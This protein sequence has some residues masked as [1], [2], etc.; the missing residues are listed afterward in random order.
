MPLKEFLLVLILLA[1]PAYA[2]GDPAVVYWSIAVWLVLGAS[3][4]F[5]VFANVRVR[6]KIMAAIPLVIAWMSISLLNNLPDYERKHVWIDA[7]EVG[8]T[9][10]GVMVSYALIRRARRLGSTK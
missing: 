10:S 9:I 7:A 3:A 4:L 6:A 1:P 8:L 5:V 2:M